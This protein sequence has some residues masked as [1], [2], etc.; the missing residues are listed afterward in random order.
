MLALLA[1]PF[2]LLLASMTT[3]MS[4]QM[5]RGWLCVSRT[6]S[7]CLWMREE[8]MG[9]Y[10]SVSS[11]VLRQCH[12]S[13]LAPIPFRPVVRHTFIYVFDTPG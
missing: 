7:F 5:I 3:V 11:D 9:G 10:G 6:L 13:P 12:V 2:D 4:I 8:M 1:R